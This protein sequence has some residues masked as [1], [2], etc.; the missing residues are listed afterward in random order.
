[1]NTVTIN[2][3]TVND[4]REAVVVTQKKWFL[5]ILLKYN[6]YFFSNSRQVTPM[7]NILFYSDSECSPANCI[8]HVAKVSHIYRNVS[9]DDIESLD[10]LQGLLSDPEFSNEI[11]SWETYQIAILEN[12]TP[13]PTPIPLTKEYELHPHIMSNRTTT[14][15]KAITAQ[16]IDDLFQLVISNMRLHFSEAHITNILQFL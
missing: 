13:L 7:L 3:L 5:D 12:V 11:L 4:V 1:M 9:R 8:S 2:N 6:I 15:V 16:K 10:E 14:V